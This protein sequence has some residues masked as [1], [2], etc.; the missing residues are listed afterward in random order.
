MNLMSKLMIVSVIAFSGAAQAGGSGPVEGVLEV[1][2]QAGKV[3]L[4]PL[5]KFS[6]G[7][8]LN[9]EPAGAQTLRIKCHTSIG[10]TTL[11]VFFRGNLLSSQLT[12]TVDSMESCSQTLSGV[13]EAVEA[14]ASSVRFEVHNDHTLTISTQH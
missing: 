9:L 13:A 1:P 7:I 8:F 2:V 4:K 14:G 11:M 12:G 10:K 5:S 3:E 6:G